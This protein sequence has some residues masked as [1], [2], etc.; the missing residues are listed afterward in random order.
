MKFKISVTDSF[1]AAHNLRHSRGKCERLHG[2]NFKVRITVG[3][4]KLD[5]LG[6]VADFHDIKNHLRLVLGQLDHNY[7]NKIPFFKKI[8]PT[9]EQIACFIFKGLNKK[10]K[11]RTCRLLEVT[12]WET[13]GNEATYQK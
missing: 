12:V 1:S 11:G 6:M 10:I 13:E 5:K 3:A 9:S 7:L 8:N 4:D 2:H